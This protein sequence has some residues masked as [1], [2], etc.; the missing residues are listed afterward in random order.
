MVAIATPPVAAND[1]IIIY[2]V[3]KGDTL[4]NLGSKYF[5]KSDDYARVQKENAIRDPKVIPIGKKLRIQRKYLKFRAS[6]A[7]IVSVRGNVTLLSTGRT[8]M[9]ATGASLGEGM[10]L[11]TGASSFATLSLENGSRIALP[12]N[13]DLK[14]VRLR[15]YVIDSSLDY[16]FS[17]GR[18]GAKST[19]TPMKNDNDRYIVRTPKATSAVRGTDF[20]AR[21]DD[22]DGNDFSEVTEG[23]LAV[24]L[25]GGKSADMPAGNGLA[26]KADGAVVQEQLLPPVAFDDAGRRQIAKLVN[27]DLPA[28]GYAGFRVTVAADGGFVEQVADGTFTG[29]AAA[30]PDIGDGNYFVRFRAISGSGIEG[31]PST[32]A[33]KRRLNSISASGGRNETG[34]A[35]KWIGEGRGELRYHFQLFK[36]RPDGTA[37]VDEAGLTA[38]QIGLSDLPDGDYYWRVASIQYLDGEVTTSWTPF[39]KLTVS[40]K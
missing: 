27:F 18:G 19:V 7:Q 8:S 1:D 4:I 31:M 29:P 23:A 13:S 37:M 16:D 2:Q 34:F 38:Q 3:K 11:K 32:Y 22:V 17:V 25:P 12:S 35:F 10:T 5:A 40:G 28:G 14:I 26:V 9:A 21:Y 33:F 24:A 39:E 20:Q 6:S 36:D 15:Q 30:F